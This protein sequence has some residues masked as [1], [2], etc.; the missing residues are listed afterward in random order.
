[1]RVLLYG[2]PIV[3]PPFL[4]KNFTA[5]RLGRITLCKAKVSP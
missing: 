2:C 3:L 1:M 5:A 4:S